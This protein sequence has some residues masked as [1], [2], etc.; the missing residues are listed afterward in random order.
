MRI[1]LVAPGPTYP[2]DSGD[3]I[4]M[5]NL[6]TRLAR[7]HCLHLICF[8]RSD[9]QR[10]AMEEM[11]TYCEQVT[12]LRRP[13]P[14]DASVWSKAIKFFSG[15]AYYIED[16]Q[17]EEMRDAIR[18]ISGKYRFDLA[19]F[20][21]IEMAQYRDCVGD[22]PA[23]L[24]EHDIFYL[25]TQ[26]Y[27]KAKQSFVEKLGTLRDW[28]KLRSYETD[29]CSTFDA[30]IV[31]SERDADILGARLPASKIVVVP[32]GVDTHFYVPTLSPGEPSESNVLVYTGMMGNLANTD[33]A[34][35]FVRQILPHV[36]RQL[37]D[38]KLYIV[39]KN[40]TVSVR[41]LGSEEG[42]TVTGAVADVRPYIARAGVY[43]VPLRIGSGTRLK[44]LEA[45]A[46]EKAVVSTSIGC[47]GLRVTD[48]EDLLIAD[49]P[50]DFAD[51]VADVLRDPSL[52]L[53]LGRNGRRLVGAEYDWEIC[54]HRLEKVFVET[55]AY[56]EGN[57][58]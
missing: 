34:L 37:S 55:C 52:R 6:I 48:G 29:R 19:H 3:R 15:D 24:T 51:R 10:K 47:E 1:L 40:P 8:V 53:R 32:N 22:I 2:P 13:G 41:D 11:R 18:G 33:A 20:D 5:Y 46:M 27:L 26:R 30:V 38:V 17:S 43:I 12:C 35:Y 16:F 58:V 39:G 4:R 14:R 44:I 56:R 28:L 49:K 7:R 25:K 57:P 42:V 45:F 36:R 23:V 54:A 21:F 31:T 9:A 50:K